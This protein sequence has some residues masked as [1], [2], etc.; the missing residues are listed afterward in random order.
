MKKDEHMLIQELF[1]GGMPA[2][3]F[4]SVQQRL[5]GDAK[6]RK[7]YL[8]YALLQHLL[9]EEFEGTEAEVGGE[10]EAAGPVPGGEARR[11]LAG[12]FPAGRGAV[13]R[14]PAWRRSRG[15]DWRG[16][17]ILALGAAAAVLVGA[18]L[19]IGVGSKQPASESDVTDGSMV[20]VPA[21]RVIG[22]EES[23][24][25]VDGAPGALSGAGLSGEVVAGARV[26]LERGTLRW[27]LANGVTAEMTAPADVRYHA[28]LR[29]EMDLGTARFD[30]P[31]S[32]TGFTVVAP[33][34]EVVD[35][36]TS[37][38]VVV[39]GAGAT[40]E[41]HVFE[42]MVELR[43]GASP[44]RQV[45]EAGQAA[46]VD[47]AVGEVA[48]FSSSRQVF[49]SPSA[50]ELLLEEDF[51]AVFSA[52]GHEGGGE[53]PA[54]WIHGTGLPV[55][56]ADGLAGSGFTVYADL[57]SVRELGPNSVLDVVLDVDAAVG[58]GFHTAGWSG[59]SLYVG[60]TEVVFFGDSY[61]DDATWSIDVKQGL[62]PVLPDEAATGGRTV[63]MRYYRATGRVALFH[64]D[65]AS[66]APFVSA[67]I[68]P[69]FDFDRVRLGA[70]SGSWLV[71]RRV[72][73]RAGAE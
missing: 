41:L 24:W 53:L 6:L 26:E 47:A 55:L 65:T 48:R 7:L 2:E 13:R 50:W 71:V 42:G 45:L 11:V 20:V 69:G 37:F 16:A 73:M 40:A 33:G 67:W 12:H 10:V 66:G 25:T 56:T 44:E 52:A 17:G 59:L 60:S 8:E 4:E 18:W 61:G 70:S 36:G 27:E 51:C 34:F 35:L 68:A 3:Q 23:V 15:S 30:V 63:T 49:E 5:R 39:P 19:M 1:D 22:T 21:A 72:E 64:G 31:S 28:P 46:R 38:G 14:M 54:D 9:M 29:M 43:T 62:P 32:G 58:P 57:P